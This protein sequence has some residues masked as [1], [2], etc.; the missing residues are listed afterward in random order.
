LAQSFRVWSLRINTLTRLDFLWRNN[1]TV[2]VPL[3]FHWAGSSD[4]SNLNSFALLNKNSNTDFIQFLMWLNAFYLFN[5]FIYGRNSKI[6]AAWYFNVTK[7]CEINYPSI[8]KVSDCYHSGMR[9]V[10]AEVLQTFSQKIL[11]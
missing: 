5:P 10:N 3:S 9:K 7:F 6:C 4:W 2:P 8:S 11:R 1:F